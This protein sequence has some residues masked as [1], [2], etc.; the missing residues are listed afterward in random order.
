MRVIENL[1]NG[2][3]ETNKQTLPQC[4]EAFLKTLE[5]V[6]HTILSLQQKNSKIP[7]LQNKKGHRMVG[8]AT[9]ASYLVKEAKIE[10]IL[11]STVEE[12]AIVQQWLEYRTSHIDR[13]SCWEDI[14]NILKDLN[15]YLEDKVYFVENMITLADILIY[16]GLHPVI[17]GLSFQEKETFVNVSRWFCHIQNYPSIQQHFPVVVFIK[18]RIYSTSH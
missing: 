17:A 11:G 9:I 18:N 3:Y 15:H 8:L 1:K 6:S 12:K 7:V 14:R 10:E 2:K 16:Y 13:V 5:S 4:N